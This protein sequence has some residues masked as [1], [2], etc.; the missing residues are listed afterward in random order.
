MVL[1]YWNQESLILEYDT[2]LVPELPTSR[3]PL[4]SSS[5]HWVINITNITKFVY[6]YRR[7]R[8]VNNLTSKQLDYCIHKWTVR[9]AM[10]TSSHQN[11]I[12]IKKDF[13]ACDMKKH[14]E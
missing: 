11:K 2:A 4:S 5:F 3:K 10:E 14:F 7:M 9:G 6:G 1:C 12:Q 13:I 8:K